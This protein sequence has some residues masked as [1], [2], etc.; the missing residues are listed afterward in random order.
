M[1]L[2]KIEWNK[3]TY[4]EFIRYLKS[5]SD[6]NYRDF[7]LKTITTNYEMLGIRLPLLR[8]MAK[9]ISKGNKEEY[10]KYSDNNYYEEVMLKGFVIASIKE[11][12]V[13][14]NYLDDYVS[15]ID[16][17]AICDSFSNSLKIVLKD[18]DYWFLYFKKYLQSPEE[19]QV[20]LGLVTYLNFFVEE[21][22]LE[23]I[24]KLI[25]K[26]KLDKYYVNM[27]I[28]WLL[29]ECFTKYPT[30]TLN[31]L[32]KSQINTF[33][34]NKTISKIRESFRVSNEMKESL[35]KMKRRDKNE[36]I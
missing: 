26:I 6:I 10:L 33:T 24:F 22:Y 19:F 4:Q 29:C 23:E 7:N 25:D 16:N 27:G 1:N 17:W 32:L 9:E 35:L 28:A 34:F 11:Q 15:L 18:K 3:K 8:K 30:E 13:L 20:R 36:K 14:L 21:K 5:L 2:E 31:F 12:E